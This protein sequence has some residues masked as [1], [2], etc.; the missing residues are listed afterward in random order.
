MSWAQDWIAFPDT[1]VP[2]AEE[3]STKAQICSLMTSGIVS[4]V[5][6]VG[7]KR[8]DFGWFG[9]AFAFAFAFD[10]CGRLEE[11]DFGILKCE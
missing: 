2:A 1:G 11:A 3:S 10:G 6:F 5:H 7:V 9:F 8:E 4:L